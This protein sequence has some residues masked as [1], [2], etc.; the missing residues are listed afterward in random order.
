M[1]NPIAFYYCINLNIIDLI[2]NFFTF[3]QEI[4]PNYAITIFSINC[5]SNICGE[6]V[7]YRKKLL[8]KGIIG[9]CLDFFNY[10]L[11]DW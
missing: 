8:D 7:E 5:L 1:N 11:N 4:A 2:L 3:D 10:K 6:A 9:K